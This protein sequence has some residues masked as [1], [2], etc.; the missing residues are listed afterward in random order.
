MLVGIE[1]G[2][3]K[4]QIGVG[5]GN[6]QPLVALER[7]EV[8]PQAGASGILRRLESTVGLLK[9]QHRAMRIGIGFGGPVDSTRGY[10]LKSHQIDGWHDFPIVAWAEKLFGVPTALAN[11]CDCA[12]LAEARFGAG[13]GKHTVFYITVG[14]GIGGGLILNGQIYRG[15]GI[16]AAE[17]GHL[18]PGLHADRPDETVEA[19]A[20]GWGIAT[21]A[22]AKLTEPISHQLKP[23]QGG[24]RTLRPEDVRQRLIEVEEATEEYAADLLERCEGRSER[25]TAKIVGQAAADG[26]E[27]AREV[28]DHAWQSLGWS[29]AQVVTLL[30]PQ[31]VVIGG[32]VAQM[33]E[34]LMFAP[35]R[36]E[37]DRYVFPPLLGSFEIAPA[38]L[39]EEVVLHGALALAAD[40]GAAS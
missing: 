28:L 35:L 7:F 9:E 10:V 25:L 34:A 29:I 33:G 6:G 1:I 3:T 40:H 23:L 27:V 16:A 38:K 32:G 37:V 13:R 30:A 36:R 17:I 8:D 22:Q 18:R 4:L 2:G 11:D 5:Q 31:I 20:S 26:N 39:E 19:V 12:G 21:A 24:I 14:S 15:S